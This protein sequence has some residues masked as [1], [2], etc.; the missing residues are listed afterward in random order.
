MC[1]SRS[2]TGVLSFE[3]VIDMSSQDWF[4]QLPLLVLVNLGAGFLGATFNALHKA[5]FKVW[6]VRVSDQMTEHPML[7]YMDTC[8]L[9][10]ACWSAYACWL[11]RCCTQHS[12]QGPVDCLGIKLVLWTAHLALIC[13]DTY[14]LHLL[15]AYGHWFPRHFLILTR[16]TSSR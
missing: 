4:R 13:T 7:I 14:L 16:R 11:I 9:P 8:T 2:K 15:C 12:P 6:T 3:G 5:L 1:L 10:L